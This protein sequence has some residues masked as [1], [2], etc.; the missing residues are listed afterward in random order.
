MIYIREEGGKIRQGFNFYPLEANQQ[1]VQIMLGPVRAQ[2]RYNRALKRW[3]CGVWLRD[4]WEPLKS[5]RVYIPGQSEFM[6]GLYTKN[7][8][9]KPAMWCRP[10]EN[11]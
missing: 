9:K 1:G 4:Y 7:T 3:R 11:D 6:D 2:L 10:S 5:Q 8:G